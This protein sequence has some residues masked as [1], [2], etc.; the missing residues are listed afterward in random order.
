MTKCRTT[1]HVLS[2]ILKTHD[3]EEETLGARHSLGHKKCVEQKPNQKN[4]RKAGLLWNVPEV[5]VA[6]AQLALL[7]LVDA[8]QPVIPCL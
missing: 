5:R 8:L 4:H 2:H 6:V 1:A 7:R 3:S